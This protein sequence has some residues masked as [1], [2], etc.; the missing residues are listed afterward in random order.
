MKDHAGITRDG[1]MMADVEK[2]R[3][4][5]VMTVDCVSVQSNIRWELMSKTMFNTRISPVRILVVF[6]PNA[7]P[8]VAIGQNVP[9]NVFLI[10]SWTGW[11]R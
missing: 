1:K 9:I 8:T 4:W 2:V 7:N 6:H 5:K 10:W 3:V 11:K